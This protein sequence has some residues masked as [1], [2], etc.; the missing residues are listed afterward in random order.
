[1]DTFLAWIRLALPTEVFENLLSENPAMVEMIFE[2]LNSEDDDNLQVAVNCIVELMSI[3]RVRK[4]NFG[5]FLDVVV[6]RV[7]SL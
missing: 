3:S 4:N 2:E 1:M 5:S 6:S 7:Q